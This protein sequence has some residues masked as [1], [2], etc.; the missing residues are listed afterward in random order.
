MQNYRKIHLYESSRE[1]KL[2]LF[3][4]KVG[5]FVQPR[6]LTNSC[7]FKTHKQDKEDGLCMKKCK[8]FLL[9]N[10]YKTSWHFKVF[11]WFQ[12]HQKSNSF[13][14]TSFKVKHSFPPKIL[15]ALRC[16]IKYNLHRRFNVVSPLCKAFL[17]CK[18][19]TVCI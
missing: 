6:S 15:N 14:I 2:V 16:H 12:E 1:H 17:V 19:F 9:E 18:Q 10:V 11:F 13:G 8:Y 5:T 3:L 4:K 7:I